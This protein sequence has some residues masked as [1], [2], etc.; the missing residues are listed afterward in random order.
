MKKIII[1]SLVLIL[2]TCGDSFALEWRGLHVKA[3]S[4]NLNDA[5]ALVKESHESESSQYVL[6]LVYLNLHQ[7][8]QAEDIFKKII[9]EDKNMYWAKWGLAES[10]RR[11]HKSDIAEQLLNEV[12]GIDSKFPPACI[13]LAYIKYMQMDFKGSVKL[14]SRVIDQGRDNVDLSN[15]VR[16]LVMY[17]GAKGMIAHYGGPLSK[18]VNGLRVK[19]N[20]D[21]AEK[22]Q[23]NSPGVLFGLGSYYLLAPAIAAGDKNKAE[24]YLKKTIEIDPL[25][26]DAYVR[27]AQLYNIRKDRNKYNLYMDKALSIDPNNELILDFKSGKC[28]FVCIGEV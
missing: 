7:D 5:L 14:A 26:V 16:G 13:S 18:I 15:Y 21:K 28:R 12:L 9:I 1:L 22:L 19:S 3:D 11:Q 10:L 23:P 27:L 25:F 20:L 17:A 4:L 6:G 8:S 2:F 24:L